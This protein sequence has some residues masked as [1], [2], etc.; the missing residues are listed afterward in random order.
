MSMATKTPLQT[1]GIRWSIACAAWLFDRVERTPLINN[2]V[3]SPER[4]LSTLKR[5]S[6][7]PQHV[8]V[9]L[10]CALQAFVK[11]RGGLRLNLD[12]DFH[13]HTRAGGELEHNLVHQIS[14]LP[15]SHNRTDRQS[16]H[17]LLVTD[18]QRIG[19]TNGRIGILNAGILLANPEV[20]K[21]CFACA[22]FEGPEPWRIRGSSHSRGTCRED[23]H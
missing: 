21:G 2:Q 18:R 8:T 23:G 11:A 20:Q 13:C 19:K 17:G 3:L 15:L 6:L 4:L 22:V 1:V 5:G 7:E 16:K 9:L 12:G 14:K 10:H